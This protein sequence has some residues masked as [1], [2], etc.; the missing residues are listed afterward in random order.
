MF[1]NAGV[2]KSLSVLPVR[3]VLCRSDAI[4]YDDSRKY[5]QSAGVSEDAQWRS[6]LREENGMFPT[7]S[8]SSE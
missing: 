7:S 2:Q 6:L 8:T 4:T 1:R 3:Q 5:K